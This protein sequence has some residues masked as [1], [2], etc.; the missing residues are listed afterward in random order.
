M[1]DVMT[2]ASAFIL[3]IAAGYLFKRAGFFKKEDFRLISRIVLTITLPCA[4][5]TNFMKLNVPLYLI[6]VVPIGFFCNVLMSGLGWLL[7]R[8]HGKERQAFNIINFSGY[9]IGCFTMPYVQSFLGPAGVVS[10]CLFDAGNALLCVGGTYAVAANMVGKS[11]QRGFWPIVKKTF[12]SVPL[13]SYLIMLVISALHLPLPRVVLTFADIVGS[14]N[15]FLAMLMLGIGFEIQLPK[16]QGARIAQILA[17]R[18]GVAVLVSAALFFL[19]PFDLEIRQAMA[20][21][22]FAPVSAVCAA[23]TERIGGD[24]A[25]SACTNSISILVSIA[26]LTAMIL[27]FGL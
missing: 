26:V 13:W 15:G 17:V 24:V 27:M 25:L 18:Y 23:Y 20:L 21:V 19:L 10:T 1:M 3:C 6:W 4:V 12:S 11:Q 14:A 5:I 9:N 22:A 2:R 7:G 8:R 16:G